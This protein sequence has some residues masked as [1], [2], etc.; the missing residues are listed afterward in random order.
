MSEVPETNKVY[1]YPQSSCPCYDCRKIENSIVSKSN[2][3]PSNLGVSD[4][5]N[6]PKP[7]SCVERV[8]MGQNIEPGHSTKF[9]P[10]DIKVLNPNNYLSKYEPFDSVQCDCS[11]CDKVMYAS[12]DPRLWSETR[13]EYQ[14]LNRPPISGSVKLKDVY[15][16]DLRD[17]GRG[18]GS[19]S[20]INAGQIAYYSDKSRE[21]PYYPPLFAHPVKVDRNLYRDPMGA[22]KPEYPR[23][24]QDKNKAT[25]PMFNKDLYGLTFIRDTNVH[26]EDILTG[27]MAQRNQQRWEPRWEAQW[28]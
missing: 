27:Q 5:P 20:D 3:N 22:I 18:Y 12:W 19:Y 7:L 21:N 1:I 2:V 28:K 4:C 9:G 15:N 23:I 11:G 16:D 17:Y 6:I 25:H 26:R 10:Q 14:T 13:S 8:N 24:V